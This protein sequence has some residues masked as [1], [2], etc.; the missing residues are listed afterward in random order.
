[1]TYQELL[2]AAVRVREKYNQLN[3]QN[4]GGAWDGD[5]LMAGFVGDVGDLSKIVMAKNG[6]RAM[7]D[8]DTKLRHELSDCLWSILVLANYYDIDLETQF[9]AS[10]K[11]LEAR[12]DSEIENV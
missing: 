11:E 10:M 8:V 4:H 6:Y 7:E 9:I 1:M 3:I 12:V 2:D 5:K